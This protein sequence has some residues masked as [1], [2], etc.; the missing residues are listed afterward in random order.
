MSSG[1]RPAGAA[2]G[3]YD[4]ADGTWGAWR[5]VTGGIS[6]RTLKYSSPSMLRWGTMRPSQRGRYQLTRPRLAMRAGTSRQRTT[7][8]CQDHRGGQADAE[9]LDR[10]IAV[11]DET[12][13]H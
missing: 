3:G 2:A 11:E 10:R 12:A 5:W 9:Q 8:A 4:R 7:V 1:R 6:S 13:E